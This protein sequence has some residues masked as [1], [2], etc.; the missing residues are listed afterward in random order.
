MLLQIKSSVL[1]LAA[2][3]ADRQGGEEKERERE[4]RPPD[5]VPSVTVA[6]AFKKWHRLEFAIL[7][8]ISY[9]LTD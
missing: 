3:V 7:Q 6:V 1:H 9:Y 2:I 5:T 8:R 4:K